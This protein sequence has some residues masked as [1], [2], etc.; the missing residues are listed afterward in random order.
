VVQLGAEKEGR[1]D[2]PRPRQAYLSADRSERY[3]RGSR[4]AQKKRFLSTFSSVSSTEPRLASSARGDSPRGRSPF[5]Q[6]LD[7]AKETLADARYRRPRVF[8]A[9]AKASPA[10]GTHLSIQDESAKVSVAYEEV[11]Q[12]PSGEGYSARKSCAKGKGVEYSSDIQSTRSWR[13]AEDG[14]GERLQT[15]RDPKSRPREGR[16]FEEGREPRKAD[17][18]RAKTVSIKAKRGGSSGKALEVCLKLDNGRERP[19]NGEKTLGGTNRIAKHMA[20]VRKAAPLQQGLMNALEENRQR[21]KQRRGARGYEPPEEW[22]RRKRTQSPRHLRAGGERC[23]DD[24]SDDTE[25]KGEG[26]RVAGEV[27]FNSSNGYGGRNRNVFEGT[28]TE[29]TEEGDS[30]DQRRWRNRG[31]VLW[32]TH[33]EPG[34]RAASVGTRCISPNTVR[35]HS[36]PAVRP[37]HG[38]YARSLRANGIDPANYRASRGC[39]GSDVGMDCAVRDRRR[40][41]DGSL[42]WRGNRGRGF[43]AERVGKSW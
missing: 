11:E 4:G 30:D 2:I 26:R 42:L 10:W 18:R 14:N 17:P 40:H 39:G 41:I 29:E 21:S 28:R 19:P 7:E 20:P 24:T 15:L 32:S 38:L 3:P 22:R 23:F 37:Y 8:T 16:I 5:R 12:A 33:A 43:A 34:A 6:A 36:Q 25:V 31:R 13:R 9:S 27:E 1:G 35:P